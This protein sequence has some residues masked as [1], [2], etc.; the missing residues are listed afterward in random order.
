VTA[1]QEQAGPDEPRTGLGLA[2]LL[3][4]RFATELAMLTVLVGAG[5]DSGTG[6]AGR[7]VLAIAGPVLAVLIWAAVIAP[8]ARWRLRDPLRL[9][10]EIV[11][12]AVSAAAL[13]LAGRPVPAAIFAVAAIGTAVLLR[14]FAPGS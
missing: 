5:L 8:R 13:A 2:M 1:D 6:G 10:V 7:I 11:M 12:F 4:L 9:A 3:T 14:W